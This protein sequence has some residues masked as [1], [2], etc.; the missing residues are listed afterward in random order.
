MTEQR[1]SDLEQ[2]S[3]QRELDR[4]AAEVPEMP[5][6]F[7][8]GWRQAI[9]KEPQEHPAPAF[10]A[11]VL[12]VQKSPEAS[13]A[14]SPKKPAWPWRRAL[15]IAAMAAFLLGGTLLGQDAARLTRKAFSPQASQALPETLFTSAPAPTEAVPAAGQGESSPS[16]F[17]ELKTSSAL[18]ERKAAEERTAGAVSSPETAAETAAEAG[19][20]SL[21]ANG[22]A[23]APDAA[24]EEE[25]EEA[26]EADADSF[27]P[28]EEALAAAAYRTETEVEEAAEADADSFAPAE[29]TLAAAAYRTETLQDSSQELPSSDTEEASPPADAVPASD[30]GVPVPTASP[31]PPAS[32]AAEVSDPQPGLSAL[33]IAGWGLV[34]LSFVLTALLLLTRKGTPPAGKSAYENS[35]R[36][37]EQK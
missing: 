7:R 17:S 4:M 29:E 35:P 24:V 16:F 8:Q 10:Q 15:S 19:A 23:T 2:Q 5:E 27:A 21:Q 31:L 1:K 13:P 12:P 22:P 18:T 25:V 36:S 3:L 14:P 20:L 6:S 11:P 37:R 32:D 34:G 33:R 30:A 9:R 26:A 28:A